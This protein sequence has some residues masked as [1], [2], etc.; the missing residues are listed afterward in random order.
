MGSSTKNGEFV[1]LGEI[2]DIVQ[3][4]GGLLCMLRHAQLAEADLAHL[5]HAFHEDCECS[6][7]SDSC[8]IPSQDTPTTC[9]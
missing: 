5:N 3:V 9:I 2:A 6:D 8:E 4:K 1:R 7:Y